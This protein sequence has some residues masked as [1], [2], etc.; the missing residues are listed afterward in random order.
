MN[1]NLLTLLIYRSLK[2]NVTEIG[3]FRIGGLALY[4]GTSYLIPVNIDEMQILFAMQMGYGMACYMFSIS[5][6]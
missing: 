2:R 1:S 3:I 5:K 6:S 4:K